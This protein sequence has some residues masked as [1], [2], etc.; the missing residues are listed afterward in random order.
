MIGER[1]I[2]NDEVEP[3]FRGLAMFKRVVLA[4]SGGA[5]SMALMHLVAGWRQLRQGGTPE[6]DVATVDHRLRA[7]ARAE[8]LWVAERAR[9]LGFNHTTLVWEEEKPAAGLQEAAREARYRLLAAQAARSNARPIAIV[10]AHTEDD[11]A[12]TLVMRLGRGSGIDGLAGMPRRRTL[13]PAGD[14]QLVRPLLEV[15]RERLIATLRAR[16]IDWLEDPSNSSHDF[17]RVRVRAAQGALGALGLGNA[18][19]ALTARRLAR[20]REALNRAADDLYRGAVDVHNGAFASIDRKIFLAA[21]EELR[22]RVLIRVLEAFGGEAKASR[23][24]KVESL[25]AAVEAAGAVVR[26][27]GGCVVSAG[28]REI[29]VF[30]E[31]GRAGL[32]ELELSPGAAAVWDRRFRVSVAIAGAGEIAPRP[33]VVR[34]LGQSDYATLRGRIEPA[35]RLPARAALTLPSFWL[36]DELIAV[37]PLASLAARPG[38]TG[39]TLCNAEFIG[40]S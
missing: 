34:A 14:I 35:F 18:K 8:A 6:I 23:L 30:R 1:P 31:P 36:N 28:A 29:R 7:E 39:H 13:A 19:L 20:A 24:A 17:E 38:A 32:P 22:L 37:P 10:T 26:T 16:G 25:L 12:E 15:P 21:P 4:V 5:D 40:S 2:G 3:L 9:A 33:V 27:L 11:Q